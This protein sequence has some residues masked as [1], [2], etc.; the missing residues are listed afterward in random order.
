MEH[1]N[2]RCV[3]TRVI[4]VAHD[5]PEN[6]FAIPRALE[7]SSRS[8]KLVVAAV[9]ASVAALFAAW[10]WR[11]RTRETVRIVGDAQSVDALFARR[12]N[13]SGASASG[14]VWT[15]PLVREPLDAATAIQ[16]FG[17][18]QDVFEHDP[19]T[20]YRYKPGLVLHEVWPEH[21]G[22]FFEKRTNSL[23]MRE[24]GELPEKLDA[25]VIA[26]GDSHVDGLCTNAESFPNRLE[27]ALRARHPGAAIEVVNTGVSGFSFYNYLGALEKFADR[28]PKALVVAF[29]SGNDFLDVLKP[30]HYFNH[31]SPPPRTKGYWARI[32]A[33]RAV[34]DGAVAIAF[35]QLVYFQAYPDQVD[36]SVNA[37]TRVCAEIARQCAQ[38]GV[39]L[40]FVHIPT[41]FDLGGKLEPPF[42]RVKAVLELSDADLQQYHALADRLI[43]ALRAHG[44]QVIDLRDEFTGGIRQYYWSDLHINVQGHQKVADRLL[45]R[46]E[47]ACG[48]A[49]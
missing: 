13:T 29:Y 40:T 3:S 26:T 19:F 21:D 32:D 44:A 18:G 10:F 22:G 12:Q 41:G 39:Q 35:N 15:S 46:V 14:D 17:A 49:R 47:A 7:M 34:S 36:V 4:L 37:A 5:R 23:G 28:Q 45:P 2:V 42:D 30:W 43:R 6:S 27:S 9:S 16:L 25:L 33:A 11:Q 20:F 38:R 8:T 48:F 1:A 31:T 24:D